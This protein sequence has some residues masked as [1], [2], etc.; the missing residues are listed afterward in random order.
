M[1][2][3]VEFHSSR[4]G[5]GR[6]PH[7]SLH[8]DESGLRYRG[9]DQSLELA[10][11]EVRALIPA[12]VGMPCSDGEIQTVPALGIVLRRPLEQAALVD[13][14]LPNLDHAIPIGDLGRRP[15]LGVTISPVE[16]V[17][18]AAELAKASGVGL[19]TPAA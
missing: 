11:A 18:C 16:I 2:S 8:L 14:A 15:L 12:A 19:L 1:A 7:R 10:W 9:P 4:L 17:N 13:G 3:G 6:Q 5:F